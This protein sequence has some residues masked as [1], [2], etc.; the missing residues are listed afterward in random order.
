MPRKRKPGQRTKS[1]RL[2]RAYQGPARDSGTREMQAKRAYLINGSDPQLAASASGILLANGFL[3]RH[4]HA[5]ALTYAWAHALTYGRP[6][7]QAC[8]LGDRTGSAPSD[9]RLAKAK[10]KLAEMDAKLSPE[11]RHAVGNVAV[12]GFVP[13]WFFVERGCGGRELPEDR[14]DRV[15]LLSGLDALARP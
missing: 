1:G 15:A 2:S 11:Q 3:T 14:T 10:A 6:W 7:R 12:F 5:A 8:P 13:M 4:Q 9:D